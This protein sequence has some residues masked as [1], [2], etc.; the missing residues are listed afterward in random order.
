MT[1]LLGLL[2]QQA[3]ARS[4][5]KEPNGLSVADNKRPDGMTLLP[6]LEDMPL[7]WDPLADSHVSGCTPAAAAAVNRPH[8]ANLTNYKPGSSTRPYFSTASIRK[9]YQIEYVSHFT[10]I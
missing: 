7:A 8:L 10:D 5:T 2:P 4:V 3:A 1:S 6:W 9:F